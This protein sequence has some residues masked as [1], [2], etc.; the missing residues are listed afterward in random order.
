MLTKTKTHIKI[1][2]REWEKMRHNP[3]LFDIV[4]L[5]EDASDLRAAM[6]VRGKDLSLKQYLEKRGIRSNHL[7]HL[8]SKR[9]ISITSKV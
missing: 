9:G 8:T 4:E 6:N 2:K 1:P 3:F 5:L 7:S